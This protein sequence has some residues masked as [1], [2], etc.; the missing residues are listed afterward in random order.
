MPLVEMMGLLEHAREEKY[1][2]GYFE[3]WDL[4]SLQATVAAAE[5]ENS[6]LILGIGGLSG[7]HDW[8]R[9]I[10]IESYATVVNQ[11]AEKATVPIA[12]LFN[13]GNSV[14]ESQIAINAGYGA[15]MMHTEGWAWAKLIEDTS[16]V[17]QI[18]HNKNVAVEGEVGALPEITK[19]E[20]DASRAS[21]TTVEQA[22]AFVAATKVDCLAVAVGNVHF[23]TSEFV[24]KVDIN[25]IKD[26]FSA[27]S[28]PLVMHGGSGT[29]DDQIRLAIQAGITKINVGTKLKNVYAKKLKEVIQNQT[30]WNPNLVIGSHLEED[31]QTYAAQSVH[32][33]VRRLINVF[34]SKNR[35]VKI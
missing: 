11:L 10:G 32:D 24:P 4:Y 3:S 18:A 7:N 5:K 22:V 29:P 34:G 6:P 28:V 17:V 26:I 33:E 25:R 27:V 13:E 19:G 23:V 8:L 21:F 14:L 16:E 9:K 35:A 31:W 15:V 30:N 20:L 2:V 12:T 1:A